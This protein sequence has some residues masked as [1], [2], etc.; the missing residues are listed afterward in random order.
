MAWGVK[1][2]FPETLLVSWGFLGGAREAKQEMIGSLTCISKEEVA[3]RE[4]EAR[5]QD[6]RQSL[7]ECC[8]QL[9]WRQEMLP[10]LES[11]FFFSKEQQKASASFKGGNILV[12][13]DLGHQ[14]KVDIVVQPGAQGG[15][16]QA[17]G[18]QPGCVSALL[19]GGQYLESISCRSPGLSMLRRLHVT[20]GCC[21]D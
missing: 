12:A 17:S 14:E 21:Q 1:S 4:P 19:G 5:L 7:E 20:L 11:Y 13:T 3:T 6:D 8:L 10:F 16:L 2:S 18:P 9:G 15:G